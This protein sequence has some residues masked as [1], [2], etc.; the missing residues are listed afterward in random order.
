MKRRSFLK[1]AALA[2]SAVAAP[3]IIPRIVLGT[4]DTPSANERIGIGGIG[5]GRR[6]MQVFGGMPSLGRIVAIADVNLP[7]GKANAAQFG[8]DAYQDYRKL[9]ERKD[10]DAIVTATPDHWRAIVCIHAAQAGKDIYA[11]KPMTLTIHEGRQ[12]VKAV[13]KYGRVFQTGSQQRS[14]PANRLACELV[15]NG[16]IGKIREVIAANY[17]SPWECAFPGQ[18]VPE[19]LDWDMWCGP[20]PLVPYHPDLYAPRAN[21]GWISFRPYSGGEIT[22]WGAHGF[23][24][25]QWALGKDD[26]GPVEIWTEGPKFNPPTYTK[27][28]SRAR[29]EEICRVPKVCFKYADGVVVRLDNGPPGGGIFIGD[30]G[31]I[32]IDR[33]RFV[34]EPRELAKPPYDDFT[35]HLYESTNHLLNWLECIK[36]REKPICDVEIGHR[37]TTVCHLCNIARWVGRPLKWDPVKEQFEGDDEANALLDR[38]RR[39]PYVLPEV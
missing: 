3:S 11:E 12:V 38:E 35:V 30:K 25:I 17:P 28:E 6:G 2:T 10:V 5:I 16:R 31:K 13:R 29:G 32:T 26:T 23:D 24:Q 34:V 21:P 14:M 18:P 22:G 39:K 27:P 33:A 9:L 20:A 8:A 7:R 4:E 37:S 15:R 1:S 36:T 19:G